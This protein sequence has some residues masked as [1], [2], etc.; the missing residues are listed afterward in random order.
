MQH[1]YELLC[2]CMEKGY[3]PQDMQGAIT[4]TLYEN[5]GECS[6]CNNNRDISLLSI[7]GKAFVR[8]SFCRLQKLAPCI[9][10]DSQCSFRP[11][12]ST[13]DMIFLL[14][15]VQEKCREQ[16][17]PLYIAFINL[18]KAFD[19]VCRKGLLEILKKIGCATSLLN[20]IA[21]FFLP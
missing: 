6:D 19:H 12:R 11:D 7:V 15:Q 20:I 9:Y 4:V 14:R 1:L 5:K 2:L 8:V 17:M 18:T 3:F 16:Q 10:P 13:A 21:S